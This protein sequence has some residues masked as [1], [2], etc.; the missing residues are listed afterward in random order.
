MRKHQCATA[1]RGK[2]NIPS[3]PKQTD[4]RPQSKA[5]GETS[6]RERDRITRTHA[7]PKTSKNR[8]CVRHR[9]MFCTGPVMVVVP[10]SPLHRLFRPSTQ[11][12]SSISSSTSSSSNSAVEV[13][14]LPTIV[15]SASAASLAPTTTTNA[16][17]NNNLANMETLDDV[18]HKVVRLL[19]VASD[20]AYY[21]YRSMV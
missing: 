11:C 21:I 8:V 13:V 15:E 1:F 12:D 20:K 19:Y 5:H 3:V 18:W 4:I 17:N 16:N 6:R 10:S 9:M 14:A 2:Q 7:S